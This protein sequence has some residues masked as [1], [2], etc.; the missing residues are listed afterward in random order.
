VADRVRKN[1]HGREPTAEDTKKAAAELYDEYEKSQ[2]PYLLVSTELSLIQGGGEVALGRFTA[3][4][5]PLISPR[6][7]FE[8]EAVPRWLRLRAGSYLELP[9]TEEGHARVHGTGGLDVKLFRWNVFGLVHPFDYWQLSLAADGA[10]SYLNTSF[11]V[12]FWH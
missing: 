5:R 10:K 1:V 12:G 3:I 11:S 6:I 9:T 8:G 7:G 4:N 2:T